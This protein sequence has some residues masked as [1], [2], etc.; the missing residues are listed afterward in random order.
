[1][2]EAPEGTPAIL[3]ALVQ[4][5]VGGGRALAG[6]LW[7]PAHA[8]PVP[9][10]VEA[11][12]Y[13]LFDAMRPAQERLLRVWAEAGYAVLAL[14]TAGAGGSAGILADEYLAGEID[15]ATAA[16]AWCA[17]QP[18]CDGA[19]GMSGLSWAGFVA[20]RTAARR[21]PALKALALGGVS[22]DGWRTDIHLLGGASY[23]ARVD[24]AGTMLAFNA[25]PPDPLQ[26]GPAW[27]AEWLARLRA[28]RPW[29][30]EWLAHPARDGYWAGKAAALD[31]P[32]EPDIPL[33]L[34]AGTA[35]KYATSVLRIAAGWRG[36]VRTVLGPWEHVPPEMASRGPRIGFQALATAWWDRW[37][38]GADNGIE[39]RLA[40]LTAWIGT[41]DA[42]GAVER[43]RWI[44]AAWPGRTA[45]LTLTLPLALDLQ[46]AGIA[47]APVTP[48]ALAADLYE[49]APAPIDLAGRVVALA[50]PAGRGF[51]ILGAPVLSL[52]LRGAGAGQLVARL[53]DLAPDGTAVRMSLGAA[54][55]GA[56]NLA[57]AAS[58]AGET[59]V[60]IALQATAWR[61]AAGHR[62]AV[63]L[64]AEGWPTLW[65]PRDGGA[66]PVAGSLRLDLPLADETG[67]AA[68]PPPP[69]L[70]RADAAG[71]L[72]W[73]TPADAQP[74]DPGLDAAASLAGQALGHHLAATGT[75]Y[76]W[77]SRFDLALAGG[78]RQAVA[79]K[80]AAIAFERP[81]WSV[82]VRAS[83]R[84][85]S[86]AGTFDIDWR[87]R[88][89]LDG[90]DLFD[91]AGGARVPRSL[92]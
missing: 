70:A 64:S 92:L 59:A 69:R 38:K 45:P 27:R 76:L 89:V 13:R 50:A 82:R 44:A 87:V 63:V 71:P 19:V 15:D 49:D 57:A 39:A 78:G 1:M 77:R 68:D 54:N 62:L 22:E 12:P 18:W 73:L 85:A 84:V 34:Y 8:W 80:A 43:G 25:L 48:A 60:E 81:G 5:P 42:A 53:V 31:G 24:W 11:A 91:A 6:R 29:I 10:I 67:P 86:T 37:L 66:A 33:L 41:P 16:V 2:S 58:G 30:A 35:D 65:P 90:E 47:P 21:P 28:D 74:D 32:G 88:A 51:N 55:L 40:P 56:A 20:L 23:A 46:S 61:L 7:R 17:A 79:V 9:A 72:Q 75:D 4:V 26:F 14:D 3:D 36:P 83:L 52:R